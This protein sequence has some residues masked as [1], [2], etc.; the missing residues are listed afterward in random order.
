MITRLAR[1]VA[2]NCLLGIAPLALATDR[3]F[4]DFEVSSPDGRFLLTAKSPD[5]ALPPDKR[6]PFQS[7]FTFALVD[8]T[9][10]DIL[11]TR[12]NTDWA[13]TDL[14]VHT[15]ASVV[16]NDRGTNFIAI[17][18]L[19]GE[20]RVEA[21]LGQLIPEADWSNGNISQTSIGPMWQGGALFAFFEDGGEVYFGC[22]TGWDHVFALDFNKG[23]ALAAPP[24]RLIAA[25]DRAV[26]STAIAVLEREAAESSATRADPMSYSAPLW[27]A[28]EAAGRLKIRSAVPSLRR[29]ES[30]PPT[31][32]ME[33]SPSASNDADD[34]TLEVHNLRQIVRL[35]LRRLGEAPQP[36]PCTYLAAAASTA[37]HDHV[38]SLPADRLAR[39][40]RLPA[41]VTKADLLAALGPPEF[42]IEYWGGAYH[43]FNGV[44]IWEYELEDSGEVWILNA[45]L[46]NG[47]PGVWRREPGKAI[48]PLSN[49]LRERR[50]HGLKIEVP[51]SP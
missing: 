48:L 23:R 21:G 42:M 5:N 6:P 4:G 37:R 22:R 26:T 50:M 15:D 29:L 1:A 2:A 13:P 14:W 43:Q 10:G 28:I 17:R 25:M 7:D 35:A 20:L 39:A 32:A 27:D 12:E 45:V 8:T 30:I 41:R 11:W 36:L 51:A 38:D 44:Q 40:A 46:P 33:G 24:A 16:I 49:W 47:V 19:T 3:F 18:S 34:P 31:I 9:T